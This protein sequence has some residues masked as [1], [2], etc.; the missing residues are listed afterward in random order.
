[1]VHAN[2]RCGEISVIL[3][4]VFRMPVGKTIQ[5]SC[6]V[7][8]ENVRTVPNRQPNFVFLLSLENIHQTCSTRIKE[9]FYTGM[10]LTGLPCNLRDF[11]SYFTQ[12]RP[13]LL[14]HHVSLPVR[15]MT[16]L[17]KLDLHLTN[18]DWGS[19]LAG[20]YISTRQPHSFLPNACNFIQSVHLSDRTLNQMWFVATSTLLTYRN[21]PRSHPQTERKIKS[22]IF[23]IK[24]KMATLSQLITYTE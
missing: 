16:H 22:V 4:L 20:N 6:K 5:Q 21:L 23:S 9:D 11:L 7:S 18:I 15:L 8:V 19:T 13:V 24:T 1:M 12:S 14:C 2:W 17:L 3:K 10:D